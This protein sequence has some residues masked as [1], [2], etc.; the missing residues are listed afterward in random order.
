VDEKREKEK[1]TV[2]GEVGNVDC[3]NLRKPLAGQWIARTQQKSGS[4]R[5]LHRDFLNACT[6]SYLWKSVHGKSVEKGQ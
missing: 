2:T 4:K 1:L 5:V 3:G 6:L